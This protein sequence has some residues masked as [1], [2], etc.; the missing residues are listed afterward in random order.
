MNS[1]GNGGVAL[2]FS[3]TEEQIYGKSSKDDLYK[4]FM[5]SRF[6]FHENC[7]ETIIV[8]RRRRYFSK[9]IQPVGLPVLTAYQLAQKYS[10]APLRLLYR[11]IFSVFDELK[12]Q[13]LRF[14]HEIKRII[15]EI[16]SHFM[17]SLFNEILAKERNPLYL[18][19]TQ[20]FYNKLPDFFS[21]CD[22]RSTK[23]MIWYS[24]NSEVISK[25][26]TSEPKSLHHSLV[27][28]IDL[29]YAW[30]SF[31]KEWLEERG[32]RKV[33]VKKSMVFLP[34]PESVTFNQQPKSMNSLRF[35]FFDVTPFQNANSIYTTDAAINSVQSFIDFGRDLSNLRNI[36]IEIL[37]KPKR[38]YS[39][40]A[41]K[42]Y[43]SQLQS[44][45]SRKEITLLD[46]STNLYDLISSADI[47]VAFPYSSPV[48]IA[49]ELRVPSAFF[50]VSDEGWFLKREFFG[51]PVIQDVHALRSWITSQLN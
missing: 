6:P 36:R 47:V 16:E 48:L 51:I 43:I 45:S 8:V 42:R 41:S 40:K 19:A 26:T 12:F 18:V 25:D 7:K 29:H 35:A 14:V 2:I 49:Q 37:I 9:K 50:Y 15:L 46:S 5:Q 28:N 30:N 27:E 21:F 17:K 31:H 39:K 24:I 34:Y 20:T 13:K 4:F 32:A 33:E 44:W 11:S 10:D 3:L 22:K 1:K 38:R 23:I